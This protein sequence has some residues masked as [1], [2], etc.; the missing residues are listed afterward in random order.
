MNTKHLLAFAILLLPC[1]SCG[2]RHKNKKEKVGDDLEIHFFEMNKTYGDSFLV[3]YHDYEILVDGGNTTDAKTVRAGVKKY[4][5][6]GVLEML[7]ATHPHAD[8]VGG[9]SSGLAFTDLKSITTIVDYGYTYS[10]STNRNYESIRT[11]F[12]NKGSEYYPIYNI[13]NE[14]AHSPIFNIDDNIF[15]EFLNTNLYLPV[16]ETKDGSF[17]HNSASVVATINYMNTKF[18]F[19][20]DIVTEGEMNIRDNY[21]NYFDNSYTI[22]KASHHGSTTSNNMN[23]L[24]YVDPKVAFI[25]SAIIEDNRT[26]KGIVTTQHPYKSVL[27]QLIKHTSDIYWTGTCGNINAICN[28][29][30]V[31]SVKGEGATVHYYSQG[32]M[33]DSESEKDLPLPQ[34]RWYEDMSKLR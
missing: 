26:E 11:K 14:N 21:P 31:T 5:T 33:V 19:G 13:F 9:L 23:F 4:C 16:G 18:Y 25:S 3:K 29:L 22:Y 2:C 10:T 34:T 30:S 32:L 20:G 17:D 8:H 7:I 24:D 1:I 6:D 27:N 28:G 12:V 15:I